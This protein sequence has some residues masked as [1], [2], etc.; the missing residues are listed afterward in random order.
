MSFC[1]TNI[2]LKVHPNIWKF[3]KILVHIFSPKQMLEFITTLL[4]FCCQA[5]RVSS[6]SFFVSSRTRL[7]AIAS[8]F[9]SA[10]WAAV[11]SEYTEASSSCISFSSKPPTYWKHRNNRAS[12]KKVC[13]YK[14]G[15]VLVIHVHV[16]KLHVQKSQKLQWS[17][18]L[19]RKDHIY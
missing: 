18:L 7:A 19:S 2:Q 11:E 6:V 13:H 15:Q 9:S 17:K 5:S 1:F 16:Y 8:L 12:F 10:S 14:I 3:S 4:A